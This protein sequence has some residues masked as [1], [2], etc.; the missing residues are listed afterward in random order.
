MVDN[1]MKVRENRARRAA[2]RQGLILMKART[3]DPK[4][5]TFGKWWLVDPRTE[6]VVCGGEF[7]VDLD[8]IEK[9]LEKTP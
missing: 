1:M 8:R 7:G 9:Q 5:T 2:G 3:R 4:A 6:G